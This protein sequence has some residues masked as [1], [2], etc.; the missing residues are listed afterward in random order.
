[1]GKQTGG[2]TEKHFGSPDTPV[3]GSGESSALSGLTAERDEL[4]RTLDRLDVFCDSVQA[5]R[6]SLKA[7]NAELLAALMALVEKCEAVPVFQLDGGKASVKAV[8]MA[9]KFVGAMDN[10]RAAIAK[11]RSAS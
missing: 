4:R 8:R 7:Q 2:Q 6:D 10:A 9:G 3:S 5:Q 11:A 1:M